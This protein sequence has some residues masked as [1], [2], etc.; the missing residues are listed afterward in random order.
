MRNSSVISQS[1]AE[2]SPGAGGADRASVRPWIV[3]IPARDRADQTIVDNQIVDGVRRALEVSGY[4]QLCG[5]RVSCENGR[6]TL[7][8]HIGSYYLKQVAQTVL[9]NIPGIH[10]IANDLQVVSCR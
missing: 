4:P 7:E 3:K 5:I 8:G 9:K 10:A 6:L 2:V 1:R